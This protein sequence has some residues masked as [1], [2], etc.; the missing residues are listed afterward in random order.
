M[1][2]LFS[3]ILTRILFRAAGDCGDNYIRL[4]TTSTALKPIIPLLLNSKVSDNELLVYKIRHEDDAI[5]FIKNKLLPS[6]K[7]E[8][9]CMLFL[10]SLMLTKG[11]G[12]IEKDMD[13]ETSMNTLIG[14]FGHCTQDLI[15]LLL[16]GIFKYY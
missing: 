12:L 5:E 4:V 9:G 6:Y 7:T 10:L 8:S 1:D 15:N 3:L 11:L 2:N 13:I 16:T 14:Q